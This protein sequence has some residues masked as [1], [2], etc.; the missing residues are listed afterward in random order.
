MNLIFWRVICCRHWK[1][2]QKVS[3]GCC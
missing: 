2:R 1:T 3:A